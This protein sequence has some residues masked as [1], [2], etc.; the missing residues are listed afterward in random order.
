MNKELY[1][2]IKNE[3]DSLEEELSTP[4]YVGGHLLGQNLLGKNSGDK[5]T[6]IFAFYEYMSERE[7]F[8][9]IKEG[10]WAD[11]FRN[12]LSNYL[13]EDVIKNNLYDIVSNEKLVDTILK[14]CNDDVKENLYKYVNIENTIHTKTGSDKYATIFERIETEMIN[15]GLIEKKHDIA[16][17]ENVIS[18][19]ETSKSIDDQIE[20]LKKRQESL[21]EKK[22]Q[23]RDTMFNEVSDNIGISSEKLI[24]KVGEEDSLDIDRIV[25][26][27]SLVSKLAA[28]S[29]VAATMPRNT[30]E[31]IKERIHKFRTF[32]NIE[33]DITKVDGLQTLTMSKK[34]TIFD[35][36]ASSDNALVREISNSAKK[37]L[38]LFKAIVKPSPE[39]WS[40]VKA[41]LKNTSKKISEQ[42]SKTKEEVYASYGELRENIKSAYLETKDEASKKISDFAERISDYGV[43][44]RE[45]LSAS[46]YDMA[47]KVSPKSNEEPIKEES[48]KKETYTYIN[49]P[50]G[51]RKVVVR[52]ATKVGE[53]PTLNKEESSKK[54]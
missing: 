48:P 7:T 49:T 38:E 34:E 4:N 35:K 30:Y 16:D 21:E 17:K 45:K 43:S 19:T 1:K 42:L 44:A 47:D 33:L 40:I 9:F 41:A 13:T 50:E 28:N 14:V 29:A 26:E 37:K 31:K 2:N 32:K 36:I 51:R 22:I 52:A 10:N 5:F 54:M 6:V 27:P 53:I 39:V 3:L 12:N 18:S 15:Q 24:K 20:E 11:F 23:R 8:N 46:L 25:I